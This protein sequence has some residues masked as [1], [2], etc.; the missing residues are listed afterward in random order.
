MKDYS[1]WMP[2]PPRPVRT[3]VFAKGPS[4]D[5]PIGSL[6]QSFRPLPIEAGWLECNGQIVAVAEYPELFAEIG[7][8]YSPPQYKLQPM[9]FAGLRKLLRLAWREVVPNP[10]ALPPG[11]FKLPDLRGSDDPER[12]FKPWADQQP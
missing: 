11:V 7:T 8:R 5:I 6:H 1:T 3:Y 2:P 4:T 9:R 10:A 12:T